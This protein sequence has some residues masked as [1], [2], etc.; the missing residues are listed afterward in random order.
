MNIAWN[1]G[2]EQHYNNASNER[3]GAIGA[4]KNHCCINMIVMIM[5]ECLLI[6]DKALHEWHHGGIIP[7]HTTGRQVTLQFVDMWAHTYITS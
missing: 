2:D 7:N 3:Y 5:I 6:N 1:S 4:I